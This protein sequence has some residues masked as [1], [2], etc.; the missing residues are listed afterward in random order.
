MVEPLLPWLDHLPSD[1]KQRGKFNGLR[2]PIEQAIINI[3]AHP[4]EPERWQGLLLMLADTQRRIDHNKL[5]RSRCR[6]I[7]WLDQ[8]WFTKC[9]PV[10]PAEMLVARAIASIGASTDEPIIINIYG[11][12]P[13]KHTNLNFSGEQR[14]QRVVWHSGQPLRVLADVL[15]RRLIDTDAASP[16]PLRAMHPCTAEVFVG[17][18]TRGLDFEMIVHWIP[19][20]SLIRWN[21][22]QTIAPP[23][24]ER[25][26]SSSLDGTSLLHALFRP[27]FYPGKL[28]IGGE[29][30]FPDRSLPHAITARRLLNLI[31]QEN[32]DEAIQLAGGRYL[33]AGHAT[34]KPPPNLHADGALLAAALLTP[35]Q[36]HVIAAGLRRWLQPK[37]NDGK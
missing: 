8:A 33:A 16:L 27:L 2:G 32:W 28:R 7:P 30:L 34:V 10:P 12:E 14:P 17:L 6:A 29:N 22:Q 18:M 37:R 20:F 25:T 23:A 5:L 11:V 24:Q 36:E 19:P 31:R 1:N 9:W 15:E 4:E 3:A 26:A 13:Y 21:P 35:L